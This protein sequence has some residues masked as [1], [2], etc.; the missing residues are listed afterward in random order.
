MLLSKILFCYIFR[1]T[2]FGKCILNGKV[3]SKIN[4]SE[5]KYLVKK[6]DFIQKSFQISFYRISWR[7]LFNSEIGVVAF[8]FLPRK[9]EVF[10]KSIYFKRYLIT[11]IK[12]LIFSIKTSHFL[13]SFKILKLFKNLFSTISQK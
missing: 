11:Y 8:A 2:S 7:V 9:W 10:T 1:E 4:L 3:M 5:T 12:I 6:I 13:E